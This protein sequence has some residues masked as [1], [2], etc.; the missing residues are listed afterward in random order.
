M[1]SERSTP[2][3]YSESTFPLSPKLTPQVFLEHLRKL[4]KKERM[5]FIRLCVQE[6]NPEGFA[7]HP[8][9]WEAVREWISLRHELSPRQIGLAGSAQLGFST[10]PLKNWS[11]F[12]PNNSDLDIFIVNKE[13]FEKVANEARVFVATSLASNVYIPQAQTTQTTLRRG[14][15]NLKQ[16][17]AAWDKYRHCATLLNDASIIIDKLQLHDFHLRPS[18]FRIYDDWHSLA[19]WSAIQSDSW[20]NNVPAV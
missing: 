6:R 15:V 18:D 9:L 4:P 14:Y 5:S 16:I 1:A 12:D 13:L 8:L 2:F 7:K 11:R 20:L 17:P 19:K 10:S 3:I